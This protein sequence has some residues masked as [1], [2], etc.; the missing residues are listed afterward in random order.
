MAQIQLV[1]DDLVAAHRLHSRPSGWRLIA[2]GAALAV[3]L[4]VFVTPYFLPAPYGQPDAV[5]TSAVPLLACV[6]AFVLLRLFFLPWT[7]RRMYRQQKSLRDPTDLEWNT[8]GVTFRSAS[9]QGTTAWEDFLKWKEDERLF[10]LYL[11]SCLFHMV[12]KRVFASPADEQNF[13]R[14]LARVGAGQQA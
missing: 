10:L 2:L 4:A 7:A 9:A 5:W 3:L 1:A 6:L 11:S 13:R 14:H 12:P 8:T